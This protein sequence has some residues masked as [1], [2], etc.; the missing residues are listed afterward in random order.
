MFSPSYSSAIFFGHLSLKYFKI[1]LEISSMI[2]MLLR[3][4]LF[5][6]QAFGGFPRY[7]H[8]I[9]FYFSFI[10]WEQRLYVFILLNSLRFLLCPRMWSILLEVPYEQ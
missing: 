5:N 7:S 1:S 2:H 10:I 6:V 8:V 9:N 4:L 3:S